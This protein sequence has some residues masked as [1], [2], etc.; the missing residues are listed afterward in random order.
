MPARG[1]PSP[2]WGVFPVKAG[3]C[4]SAGCVGHQRRVLLRCEVPERQAFCLPRYYAPCP[5]GKVY[6]VGIY[7]P[8]RGGYLATMVVSTPPW[9]PLVS[10]G[11]NNSP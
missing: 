4:R 1:T 7:L 8:W 10:K 2:P 11:M 6:T 9:G 5:L 3:V